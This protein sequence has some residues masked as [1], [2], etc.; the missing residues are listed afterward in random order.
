MSEHFSGFH[1]EAIDFLWQLRFNNNRDWFQAHKQ[2][3][4][5]ELYR[6]M[7][8]F[9]EEIFA[10]FVG[11]SGYCC[12]VSRIY[13]D[14]RFTHA[15]PYKESLWICIRRGANCWGEEPSLF[16]ELAPEQYSYGFLL[17]APKAAWMQAFRH[18][19]VAKPSEFLQL[20]HQVQMKTGL[21][22]SGNAYKRC[23]PCPDPKLSDWWNL[24]NLVA[25]S[26][27]PIDD[28]LYTPALADQ[29]RDTLS[30]LEPLYLYCQAVEVEL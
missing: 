20:C 10:P 8:A 16:F 30:A 6:P 24:K 23:K 15:T 14:A 4:L 29:V 28:G 7:V 11:K 26:N 5:E 22:L 3:Y 1:P 17:W 13:R 21:Q 9:S 2:V 25:I 27:H 18:K 19:I 12:K